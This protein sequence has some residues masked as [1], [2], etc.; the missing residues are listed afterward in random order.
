[1]ASS[2]GKISDTECQLKPQAA[3]EVLLVGNLLD[4][5]AHRAVLVRQPTLGQ[6]HRLFLHARVLI[7]QCSQHGLLREHAEPFQRPQSVDLGL[8]SA[9][10]SDNRLQ[11]R[12]HALVFSLDQQSL[13]RL[14]LPG[15]GV[16]EKFYQL[17]GREAQP[18]FVG[19]ADG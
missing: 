7:G 6:E 2:A 15:V 19:C 12:P 8:W 10:A 18:S 4:L 14:A 3:I 9:A 1:M 11:C 16:L 13:R 17:R 5:L